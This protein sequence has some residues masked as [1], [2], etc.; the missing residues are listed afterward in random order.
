MITLMSITG[1]S[2]VSKLLYT[3]GLRICFGGKVTLAERTWIPRMM[4]VN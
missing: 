2:S 1:P 3:L 4:R